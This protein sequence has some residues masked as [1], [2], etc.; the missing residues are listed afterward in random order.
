L[1]IFC[2]S[3]AQELITGNQPGQLDIRAA[4]DGAIRATLKPIAFPLEKIK[5]IKYEDRKMEVSIS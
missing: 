1:T 2:Y 3:Q 5:D 4:G